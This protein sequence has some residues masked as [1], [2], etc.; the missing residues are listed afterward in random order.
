MAKVLYQP[1][2]KKKRKRKRIEKVTA[3]DHWS[4]DFDSNKQKLKQRKNHE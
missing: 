1:T 4:K 2:R 3:P